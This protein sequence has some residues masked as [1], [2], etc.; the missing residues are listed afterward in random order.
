MG[1]SG[2]D[3]GVGGRGYQKTTAVSRRDGGRNLQQAPKIVVEGTRRV[4]GTFKVST[5]NSLKSVISKFFPVMSLRI[6]RKFA[7][8][9]SGQVKKMVVHHT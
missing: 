2:R 6:K 4:W 3:G 1:Q 7:N 5:T 9:S 8:D